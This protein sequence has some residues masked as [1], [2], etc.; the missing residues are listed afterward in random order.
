MSFLEHKSYN[1]C[2]TSLV[3]YLPPARKFSSYKEAATGNVMTTT[4]ARP[5]NH[6]GEPEEVTVL[7]LLVL[8]AK[9]GDSVFTDT[10]IGMAE[11]ILPSCL[12]CMHPE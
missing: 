8:G 12:T 7:A 11:V 4:P 6:Q 5:R 1:E 10:S 2:L 3:P 9:E